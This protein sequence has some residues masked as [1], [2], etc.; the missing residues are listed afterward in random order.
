MH[1]GKVSSNGRRYAGASAGRPR[2]LVGSHLNYLRRS[3]HGSAGC[4]VDTDAAVNNDAGLF[5]EPVKH[6]R[7]QLW[8][9]RHLSASETLVSSL[10]CG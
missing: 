2:E 5:C 4:A 1:V 7:R 8:E 9:V 10:P 3:W 6:A